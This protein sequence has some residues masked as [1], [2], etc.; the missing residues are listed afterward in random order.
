[1]ELAARTGAWSKSGSPTPAAYG[2]LC[3]TAESA[4]GTMKRR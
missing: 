1:M 3:F 2:G 4:N